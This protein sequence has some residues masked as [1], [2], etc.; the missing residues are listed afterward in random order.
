MTT[1]TL[2]GRERGWLS[3]EVVAGLMRMSDCLV[4]VASGGLAYLHL[5]EM[6]GESVAPL[7]MIIAVLLLLQM[8][9][10]LGA[11]SAAPRRDAAIPLRILAAWTVVVA[12]L[13]AAP[14]LYASTNLG[15][16]V[17]I[18]YWYVY[19]AGGFTATHILWNRW[20]QQR[21][22]RG[23]L[24]RRVVIAGTDDYALPL[25]RH[26]SRTREASVHV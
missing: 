25:A 1:S 2:W 9:G 20:V 22:R 13:I 4:V 26:L 6:A 23:T 10:M 11:Y 15:L 12:V 5:P 16:E 14:L 17:W 18:V 7:L 24:A 21:Y 3:E 19:G 8:S